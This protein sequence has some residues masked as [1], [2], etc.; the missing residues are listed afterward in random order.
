MGTVDTIK[1]QLANKKETGVGAAG[2][3]IQGVLNSPAMKKRFEELLDKRAPQFMSSIANLVNGDTNLKKVDQMSVI[4][5]AVVAATLDLPIDKNFGY[6]YIVPY[7]NKA[8]FI[9]GYKGYIQLALRS[10]QYKNINVLEIH[11]GELIKWDP[12]TEEIEIDFTKKKSDVVIGY[13]GYFELLNGFSKTVYWTR[14]QIEKHKNRFSKTANLS[15]SVWKTDYDA[16]AKKTVLRNLLSK[17]GI[18]SIDMQKADI[19]DEHQIREEII[20][21]DNETPQVENFVEA[22]FEEYGEPDFGDEVKE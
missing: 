17:W 18:L 2:S 13:A 6:A 21:N 20:K 8:Q 19:T 14:E 10:G 7:G 9:L 4:A 15:N 22:D 11:E 5:S 12:L 1:N 16:M 3:T